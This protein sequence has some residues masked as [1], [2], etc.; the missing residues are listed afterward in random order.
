[1]VKTE[2]LISTTEYV[3][4]KSICRLHRCHYERGSIIFTQRYLWVDQWQWMWR[5]I[6]WV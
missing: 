1:M 6:Y 3:T 4:R 2:L 5:Y